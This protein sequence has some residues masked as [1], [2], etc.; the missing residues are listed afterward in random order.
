MNLMII[1]CRMLLFKGDKRHTRVC[2]K[3]NAPRLSD[4]LWGISVTNMIQ[5]IVIKVRNFFLILTF[6]SEKFETFFYLLYAVLVRYIK[7]SYN[8]TMWAYNAY[9]LLKRNGTT[10]S[11]LLPCLLKICMWF[12]GCLEKAWSWGSFFLTI[13]SN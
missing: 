2:W 6:E 12:I 1:I 9:G 10:S 13:F 4:L 7:G 11:V 8:F 5:L 3:G